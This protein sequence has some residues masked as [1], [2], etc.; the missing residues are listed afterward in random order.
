MASHLKN[1]SDAAESGDKSKITKQIWNLV[2]DVS[3]ASGVPVANAKKL[4]NAGKY[5]A[6]D[7]KNGQF[8]KFM[9]D[10]ETSESKKVDGIIELLK[11]GSGT[12][13]IND[14]VKETAQSIAL[15]Y[16]AYE[17]DKVHSQ[18][19]S[20]IKAKFTARLKSRYLNGDDNEKDDVVNVMINSGLYGDK[21]D[22][23][24]TSAAFRA[25]RDTS[26]AVSMIGCLWFVELPAA[27]QY[28]SLVE[29]ADVAVADSNVLRIF[30]TSQ[31]IRGFQNNGIVPWGVNCTLADAY[32]AAA[33]NVESVTVG[34]YFQIV[35]NAGNQTFHSFFLCYQHFSLYL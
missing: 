1:L 8:F 2:D 35:S 10:V 7:I 34:I 32:V 14:M 19:V 22:V 29:A 24:D 23:A 12:D 30:E 6:I 21:D 25:E 16:P 5:H 27:V 3:K 18:S 33:V 20:K 11:S 9:S 28:A 15:E 4:Y 13:E 31:R 26:G 17:E